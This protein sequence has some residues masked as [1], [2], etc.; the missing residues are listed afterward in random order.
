MLVSFS[1]LPEESRVWIYQCNRT[2]TDA[3]VDEIEESLHNFIISWTAHG[4]G[5]EASYKKGLGIF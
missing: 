3:E 1:S 4:K 2:F 5:L